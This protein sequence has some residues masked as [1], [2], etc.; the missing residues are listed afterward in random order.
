MGVA[1]MSLPS[2]SSYL[3]EDTFKG[4][5]EVDSIHK[6]IFTDL[7]GKNGHVFFSSTAKWAHS[8]ENTALLTNT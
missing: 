5:W 8:A 7:S 4:F 6:D 2:E 3:D 1:Y